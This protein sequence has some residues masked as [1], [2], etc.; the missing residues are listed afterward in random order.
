MRGSVGGAAVAR[1]AAGDG[2]GAGVDPAAWAIRR[3]GYLEPFMVDEGAALESRSAQPRNG[4]A[5]KALERMD[6]RLGELAELSLDVIPAMRD[7]RSGLFSHKT[8][9]RDGAYVNQE[10]NVLYSTA[11]LVGL[12]SQR[13]RP[14]DSVLPLGP[15][16]D[17][18]HE[19][20]GRRGVPSE[21]ANLV[22]ASALAGDPRGEQTLARLAA[23]EPLLSP[24]GEL[25]QVL[26]GLVAG[27]GAFPARRDLA[28]GAAAECA[29]ELLRRFRPGAD[30]FRATPRRR[31]IPRREL[32]ES[33]FTHFAAQVY[34]LHGLAA[35]H[36]ATSASPPDA[37]ASVATRV[38]EAQG[39]LG[40]WW[41][42][43]SSRSRKVLEGYPVYSVHQDGMAFLGLME[44]EK[45]GVGSFAE[46]LCLGLDWLDG[47][48]ELGV[49]LVDTDPPLINRC[50]Q[51][52][53]SHADRA[54]GISRGNVARVIARSIAPE[55]ID[56]RD[57]AEPEELE[58]LRECRSYH[59]GWLLYA[60]SLVQGAA[61]VARKGGSAP[62][63][64]LLSANSLVQ[65]AA[66]FGGVV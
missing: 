9:I 50:I 38:V 32:V 14:V 29:A 4:A 12:L 52:T 13:R 36:L 5:A 26:Y 62:L 22:W 3:F 66:V 56:D 45:L 44:L 61:K 51:R 23:T 41:W 11:T 63:G 65:G 17:A 7:E 64:W 42:I 40:Q 33:R 35:Y 60:D 48:N 15:A 37:L 2:T 24:S 46:P 30:V 53:G 49:S 6:S 43:Y 57:E 20:V 8:F 58:V 18:A 34:P 1:H 27:A 59:L 55:A 39:P 16:M 25:G 31:V 19:A 54:Y 47:A 28:M 21:Q 10:P